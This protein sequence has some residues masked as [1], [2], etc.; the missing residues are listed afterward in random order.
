MNV[1][2]YTTNC[3]KC[4][5]LETK[6]ERKNIPYSVVTDVSVMLKKGFAQ[7]PML[8][9]DGDLKTFAEANTWVEDQ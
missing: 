8:E 4:K 3:P 9:V 2:L 6:L 5:I 1:T 7:A